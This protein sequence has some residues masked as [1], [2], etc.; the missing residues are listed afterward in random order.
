MMLRKEYPKLG[1]VFTLKLLNKN[2]TF[3]IGPEVSG[4][5]LQGTKVGSQLARDGSQK[6]HQ[7]NPPMEHVIVSP[8][9]KGSLL[10]KKVMKYL[11]KLTYATN[12]DNLSDCAI[13]LVEF[14]VG[15]EL[16]VLP[17]CS[18]GFHVE[19]IDMWLGFHSFC[20]LLP[21]E[22]SGDQLSEVNKCCWTNLPLINIMNRVGQVS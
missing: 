4:S 20:S 1:S 15:D 10:K 16:R 5:F 22:C 9:R 13:C 11:P 7:K 12:N 6:G 14:I 21:L 17:Q 2:I 18:H 19:C 8:S 3:L